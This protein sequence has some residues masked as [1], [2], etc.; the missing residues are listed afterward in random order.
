MFSFR[1][2][3]R[4]YIEGQLLSRV[5]FSLDQYR[6]S[7]ETGD[8]SRKSEDLVVNLSTEAEDSSPGND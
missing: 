4:L 2:V 8:R 7:V 6:S 3:P 5:E 1:S